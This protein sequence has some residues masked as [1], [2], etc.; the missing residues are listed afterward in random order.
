MDFKL[1]IYTDEFCTEIAREAVAKDIKLSTGICEDVLEA[2]HIDMFDGGVQVLSSD[3]LISIIAS[4]VRDAFPYFKSIIK[5]MFD[6]TDEE[7]RN[8]DIAEIINVIVGVV[9]YS[10]K[11]LNFSFGGKFKKN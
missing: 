6:L 3:S 5:R 8:T 11:T 10:M 7:V 2:V 4:I 9:Q 1:T